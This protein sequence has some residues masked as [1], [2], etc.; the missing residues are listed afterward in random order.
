MHV[1]SRKWL[2]YG[3]I[4]LLCECVDAKESALAKYHFPREFRSKFARKIR[5][6]ASANSQ[7]VASRGVNRQK[8]KM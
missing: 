8:N 1:H 6:V 7:I 5:R 3:K 4:L 2:E